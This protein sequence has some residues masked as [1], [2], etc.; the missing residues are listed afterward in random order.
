MVCYAGFDT[1]DYPGLAMMTWLKANSNLSWCA[2]YLAPAPNHPDR[3]WAGQ[4]S[5][6]RDDWGVVPVYVGQQDSRTSTEAPSSVLTADQGGLDATE[7]I[8]LA[9]SDQ[10][11]AGTVIYLDWESGS[12]DADGAVAYLRAW[13]QGIASDGTMKPGIYCSHDAAEAIATGLDTLN[14]PAGTQ[15]WCWRVD[16]ASAH[17]FEGNLAALPTPSPGDCG[18]ARAVMWQREQNAVV[19]FPVGT[20]LDKLEMDFSTS[21]AANPGCN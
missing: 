14:P 1:K 16:D 15:F 4:Y 5:A 13:V 8:R 17:P 2:Y 12:I 9:S 18:F 21:S 7:A 11:P 6:L 3:S 10:F 19:C 20:P